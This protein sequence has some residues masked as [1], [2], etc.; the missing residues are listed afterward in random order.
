MQYRLADKKYHK[1]ESN[2][3]APDVLETPNK[4]ADDEMDNFPRNYRR[5][6]VHS[7]REDDNSTSTNQTDST[8][9]NQTDNNSAST[10][11]TDSTASNQTA[12]NNATTPAPAA[13]NDTTPAGGTNS[14]STKQTVSPA[15]NQTDPD[16]GTT[17]H[18]GTTEKDPPNKRNTT[19]ERK[20]NTST[21]KIH[22]ARS[23]RLP[24]PLPENNAFCFYSPNSPLCG[25]V[26]R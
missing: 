25:S 13:R 4:D 23:S 3:H 11:Q 6:Y 8:A 5:S 14:T 20:K 17:K 16:K 7:R 19:V 1:L 22:L 9:S 12:N 10:N 18:K 15:S 26:M 24:F 21:L 2:A